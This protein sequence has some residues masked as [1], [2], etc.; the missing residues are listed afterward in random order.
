MAN[1]SAQAKTL[2]V[3]VT[4]ASSTA[5][6]LPAVGNTVRI[7]NEG[8][9]NAY[10]AI[11]AAGTTATVPT[12]TAAATETPVLAGTDIALDIDGMTQMMICAITATG[13]ATLRM[14]V[15]DGE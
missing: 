1:I 6:N 12:G 8:P 13:S 2:S 7:V 9:N 15:S 10:V 5:A 3:S 11:S 14:Q 4:T